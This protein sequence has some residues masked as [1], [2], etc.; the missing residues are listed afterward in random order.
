M[1]NTVVV[2]AQWGDE[3]KGKVVDWLARSAAMVVRYGGGSNAGHTVAVGD[4]T[5]KFH[6]VPCGILYPGVTCVIADGVV[7]DPEVLVREIRDLEARGRSVE[8]LRVSANAHVV[9]PYHRLLDRLDEARKGDFALGTTGRGIGPAYADKV[10]RV[11][12]RMHELVNP[13]RFE[14]RLREQVAQKNLVVTRIHGAEPLDADA[15]L[16]EYRAYGEYLRPYVADTATLVWEA[17]H[18]G[19]GVVFEGAQGTLLDIDLGTYPYVT[20]SHPIAGGACVGTGVGPTA[21]DAVLGVAK[22]YTTR[23]GAGVFPTELQDGVGDYIRERGNEYGTTTGRPRRCGWLDTVIL[24]YSAH[25]NGLSSLSLGH[26]DVLG[27]LDTV[28]IGV[29]YRIAGEVTSSLPCDLPHRTDLEP[30]Y[31]ELP[32]WEEDISSARSLDELPS[33]CRAYIRRVE[34]LV[35]I[36]VASVSVGPSRDQTITVPGLFPA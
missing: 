18:S 28:R 25:V 31:E 36:P 21:I 1:A 17:A 35:G 24:R 33:A 7:V 14:A 13:P 30:V 11:G 34:E 32:G 29:G 3:A 27:G 9:M 20:S 19:R 5:F 26:L 22:A 4:E 12:I 23:V 6:L 16:A 10:A 8:G 15:I 2:G